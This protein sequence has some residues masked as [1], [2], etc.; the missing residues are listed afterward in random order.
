MSPARIVADRAG[1]NLQPAAVVVAERFRHI[2]SSVGIAPS[3]ML[4]V[5][6]PKRVK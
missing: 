2:D 4:A 3:R 1:C 6:A 5:D